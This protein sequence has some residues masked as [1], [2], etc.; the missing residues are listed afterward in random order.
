VAAWVLP[1]GLPPG[2]LVI[3][4]PEF[5]IGRPVNE[6]VLW[7]SDRTVTDAAALWAGLRADYPRTG[8]WP[9]L[10]TELANGPGRP[11]H[12]GE[13]APMQLP[14]GGPD[15]DEVLAELWKRATGTRPDQFDWGD[16][17]DAAPS[18]SWPGLAPAVA[19]YVDPGPAADMVA[20]QIARKLDVFAGLVPA[21]SAAAA[22]AACGWLGAA[23]HAST[24]EVAVVLGSWQERFGAQLVAAGFH[25]LEL[26]VPRPLPDFA[27]ARRVAAEHYAFS[28]DSLG[29]STAAFDEYARTLIGLR[30]W[31]F[32][33]D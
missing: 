10:L 3:P 30:K 13:L 22:I 16:A 4:D 2:G 18:E 17:V 25:T 32:W 33:W 24:A 31:G 15:A 21:P 11:W 12:V 8:L 23:N 6:P 14:A 7:V 19:G 28:P 1:D 9:L 26:A 5:A 29:G 20:A 27:Q